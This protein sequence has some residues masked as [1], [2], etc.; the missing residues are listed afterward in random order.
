M[1]SLN[2]LWVM[3][4]SSRLTGVN[5]TEHSVTWRAEA[6][7]TLSC[8]H[9][10]VLA[11]AA[12]SATDIEP[13]PVPYYMMLWNGDSGTG[14]IEAELG[15]ST[16]PTALEIV[17]W[18]AGNPERYADGGA[19]ALDFSCTQIGASRQYDIN[20][21]YRALDPGQH[22][23]QVFLNQLSTGTFNTTLPEGEDAVETAYANQPA[24]ARLEY[25]TRSYTT[26]QAWD[27]AGNPIEVRLTNG[28]PV[29][30]TYQV[31]DEV[32]VIER[33]VNN[34][35]EASNN[36]RIFARTTNKDTVTIQ[37]PTGPFY[38]IPPGNLQYL[39]SEVGDWMEQGGLEYWTMRTKVLNSR[40]GVNSLVDEPQM[41]SFYLDNTI[42]DLDAVNVQPPKKVAPQ[43]SNGYPLAS[44]PL[45]EFGGRG[46]EPF[47]ARL[48]YRP[49]EPKR[50]GGLFVG[51]EFQ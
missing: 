42:P 44:V 5:Q 28:E 47:E 49:L 19:F 37:L 1:A 11:Q 8:D 29:E 33:L 2:K 45:D 46:V 34:P 32:I 18:L 9:V 23:E 10:L 20:V 24:V 41:G 4:H 36:N 27:L 14:T 43:D 40:F 38:S 25:I 39:R 30:T 51:I 12:S 35:F 48:R 3:N 15:A 31:T 7:H 50:Y 17:Q 21:I 22:E 6:S 26:N 13:V 16:F